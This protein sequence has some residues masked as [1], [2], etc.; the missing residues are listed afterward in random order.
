MLIISDIISFKNS[1]IQILYTDSKDK[2][3]IITS[4]IKWW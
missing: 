3:Y 2:K 1:I 4:I